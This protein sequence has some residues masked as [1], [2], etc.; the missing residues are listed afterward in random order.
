MKNVL[1]LFALIGLLAFAAS[2]E[3]QQ[4]I[5]LSNGTSVVVI[6]NSVPTVQYSAPVVQQILPAPV[7][8]QQF[9]VPQVQQFRS[10]NRIQAAGVITPVGAFIRGR[11]G[12]AALVAPGFIG[13]RLR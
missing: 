3:A 1:V 8:Q 12:G 6:G 4:V 13:F 2:A 7:I 9:I 11:R 10:C 5:T